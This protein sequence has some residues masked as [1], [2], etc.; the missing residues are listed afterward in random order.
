MSE[1]YKSGIGN[2]KLLLFTIMRAQLREN[3]HAGG[4]LEINLAAFTSVS[5]ENYVDYGGINS[6]AF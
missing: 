6:I 4:I 2:Q 5:G 3:L 1:W